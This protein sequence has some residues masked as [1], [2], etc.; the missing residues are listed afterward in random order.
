MEWI[1]GTDR[2]VAASEDYIFGQITLSTIHKLADRFPE[3]DR[4]G[5]IERNFICTGGQGMNAAMVLSGLG[6]K[7]AVGGPNWGTD[8]ADVLDRYAARQS[9]D[10][11]GIAR[12]HRYA[13]LRDIAFVDGNHRTES[14][15]A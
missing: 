1:S 10:T 11:R 15:R 7:F 9:I 6:L 2:P 13:G 4:N 3:A 8:T 12:E 5:A 14:E